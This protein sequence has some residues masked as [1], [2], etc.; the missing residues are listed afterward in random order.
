MTRHPM[1]IWQWQVRVAEGGL[2]QSKAPPNDI[3]IVVASEWVPEVN[4]YQF[5]LTWREGK[6]YHHAS[7]FV[8]EKRRVESARPTVLWA[9]QLRPDLNIRV[10]LEHPVEGDAHQSGGAFRVTSFHRGVQNVIEP[11]VLQQ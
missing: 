10:S 6:D 3:R 7:V 1:Q 5:T 11:R 4:G 8:D 9:H 2:L